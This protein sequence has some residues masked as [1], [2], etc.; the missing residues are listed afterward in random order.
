MIYKIHI[1]SYTQSFPA[2]HWGIWWY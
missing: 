2:V 1:C